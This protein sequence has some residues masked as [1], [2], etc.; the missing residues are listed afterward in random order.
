MK[1]VDLI[2]LG[3]SRESCQNCSWFQND[4]AHIEAVYRGLTTMS[5]GFASVRDRD[6]ICDHHRLYLSA[7]DGCGDFTPQTRVDISNRPG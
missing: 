2:Q 4:P 1:I 3:N 6:G 7:R 5:S